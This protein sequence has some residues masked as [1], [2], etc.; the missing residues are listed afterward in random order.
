M[1]S[2]SIVAMQVLHPQVLTLAVMVVAVVMTL[3][4]G[5]SGSSVIWLSLI[6]QAILGVTNATITGGIM[7]MASWLP[8]PYVQVRCM[9]VVGFHS[10]Y[11]HH[12]AAA[13]HLVLWESICSC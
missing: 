2:V 3:A 6:S 7:A 4:P 5:W 8:T 12:M 11:C 1:R 9:L 10:S 13:M